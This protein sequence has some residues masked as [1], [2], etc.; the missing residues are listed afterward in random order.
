[1]LTVLFHY[2]VG[3]FTALH[4]RE[5]W[6]NNNLG[7]TCWSVF[8]NDSSAKTHHFHE[9]FSLFCKLCFYT[10]LYSWAGS[11][12]TQDCTSHMMVTVAHCCIIWT[13]QKHLLALLSFAWISTIVHATDNVCSCFQLEVVASDGSEMGARKPVIYLFNICI[14]MSV[15]NP[16]IQIRTPCTSGAFSVLEELLK[17][18]C[19]PLFQVTL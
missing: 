11:A 1:M 17:I 6:W 2:T 18:S 13:K 3:L 19:F 12:G 8:L 4:W 10:A 7:W 9:S 15:G 5:K 16:T 14:C